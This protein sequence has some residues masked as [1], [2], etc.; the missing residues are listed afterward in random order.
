MVEANHRLPQ[1]LTAA[2]A[3]ITTASVVLAQFRARNAV[4]EELRKQGLK[5]SHFAAREITSWAR[6]YLDEHPELIADARP[7]IERWTAEGVFGKRAA[8][9]FIKELKIEQSQGD[10]SVANG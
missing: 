9:A 1:T 4:K 3:R 8:K 10:M 2:Q 5:V 7:V 6:V